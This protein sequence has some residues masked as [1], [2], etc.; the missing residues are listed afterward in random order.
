MLPRAALTRVPQ[1][2]RLSTSSLE[3]D[4]SGHDIPGL[5]AQGGEGPK[6]SADGGVRDSLELSPAQAQERPVA[7]QREGATAPAPE[8]SVDGVAVAA[9]PR[10]FVSTFPGWDSAG[11]PYAPQK[12]QRCS[13]NRQGA[14]EEAEGSGMRL[15]DAP[16]G[17]AMPIS[18]RAQSYGNGSF[19]PSTSTSSGFSS[20]F[21]G[22]AV[23]RFPMGG[24]PRAGDVSMSMLASPRSEQ[25]SAS[26]SSPRS[27][28]AFSNYSDTVGSIEES[29]SRGDVDEQSRRPRRPVSRGGQRPRSRQQRPRSRMSAAGGAT[30]RSFG[31][32][33]RGGSLTGMG[34]LQ[35]TGVGIS[36]APT[37][38]RDAARGGAPRINV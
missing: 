5:A 32:T 23:P 28:S 3:D 6:G 2:N 29:S 24:S 34:G 13:L 7:A 9:Q 22:P 12:S 1:A 16:E 17:M 10:S 26:L 27:S 35:V 14:P 19:S 38:S 37:P 25:S 4:M 33:G 30:P 31:G 21:G 18:P 11:P 36:T 8:M 15:M 20:G